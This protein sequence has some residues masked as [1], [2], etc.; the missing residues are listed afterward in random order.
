MID[1]K[2]NMFNRGYIKSYNKD[3]KK[4]IPLYHPKTTRHASKNNRLDAMNTLYNQV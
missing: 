3:I 2:F 4:A 1:K